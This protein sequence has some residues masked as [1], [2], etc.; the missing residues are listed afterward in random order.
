MSRNSSA[1]EAEKG[2]PGRGTRMSK[3]QRWRCSCAIWGMAPL[4]CRWSSKEGWVRNQSG[5]VCVG[6]HCEGHWMPQMG[7]MLRP[8][9]E[10]AEG[11]ERRLGQWL[12]DCAEVQVEVIK[13]G[14]R[15][16]MLRTERRGLEVWTIFRHIPLGSQTQPRLSLEAVIWVKFITLDG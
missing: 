16:T 2:L 10:R 11:R 5:G 14:I 7:E 13:D 6:V 3:A 8:G 15:V 9:A 4:I 12:R 1:K